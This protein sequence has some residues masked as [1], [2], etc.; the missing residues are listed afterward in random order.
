MDLKVNNTSAKQ[1]FR[2]IR[3]NSTHQMLVELAENLVYYV[4]WYGL[5]TNHKINVLLELRYDW[6]TEY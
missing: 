2:S 4:D 1:I 6:A 5:S 3:D